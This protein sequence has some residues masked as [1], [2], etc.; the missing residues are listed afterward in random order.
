MGTRNLA[1]LSRVS[2]NESKAA[3]GQKQCYHNI[4]RTEELCRGTSRK[5]CHIF[6]HCDW[7]EEGETL[8]TNLENKGKLF[9]AEL[10]KSGNIAKVTISYLLIILIT[11]VNIHPS[12]S[13]ATIIAFNKTKDVAQS[14]HI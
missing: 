13:F 10:K 8:T 7:N 12:I 3:V 4:M 6:R 14:F 1:P 2:Q 11:V 9:W 5:Y